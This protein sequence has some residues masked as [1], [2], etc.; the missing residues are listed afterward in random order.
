MSNA[1][2]GFLAVL[3]DAQSNY[4]L[5]TGERRRVDQ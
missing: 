4:H 3:A 5:L 1:A 2:V